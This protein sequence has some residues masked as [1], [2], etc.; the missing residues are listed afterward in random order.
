[1][2]QAQT[3]TGSIRESCVEANYGEDERTDLQYFTF[4]ETLRSARTAHITDT[5]KAGRANALPAFVSQH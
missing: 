2:E 5:K 3:G 4:P 1:M